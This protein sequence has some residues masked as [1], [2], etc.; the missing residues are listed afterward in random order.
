MENSGSG[1]SVEVPVRTFLR[2]GR[3]LAGEVGACVRVCMHA[4]C[5]YMCM[6]ACLCAVCVRVCMCV[7]MEV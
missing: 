2:Q 5:F 4:A 7:C 1:G 3:R 6:H